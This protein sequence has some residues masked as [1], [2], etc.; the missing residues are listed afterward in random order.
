MA[1]DE[2]LLQRLRQRDTSAL[3]DYLA[4]QRKPLSAFIERNLGTALR[5]KVE[6]DDIFQ[7]V[8]VEA[9]RSL[10]EADFERRDPFSWL[11]Q[12]AEHRIIDAHRRFFGAQKRD[13]AREV[14]LGSPGGDSR[15]AGI[16]DLLVVSMTTPT[17]A[18]SRQGR[19][20]LLLEALAKLPADQREA[21]RLRYVES[22][23]SKEIAGRL[24]KTDGAV[25]VMLTRAL[26]HLQQLLGPD[27]APR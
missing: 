4:A 12:I 19:E 18:L 14:P 24:G 22:L 7:E 2:H 8:S 21:L 13:A 15:H 10:A 26:G 16:I 20:V 3:A 9:V 23:P 17:Q 5:R 27:A 11:C 25:R 1:N 6:A